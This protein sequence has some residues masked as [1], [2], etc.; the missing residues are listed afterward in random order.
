MY[1]TK[2]I[3]IGFLGADAE[4]RTTRNGASYTVLSLATKRSCRFEQGPARATANPEAAGIARG[5]SWQRSL[6]P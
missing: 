3:L 1:Y 2:T 6:S 5:T 4:Q